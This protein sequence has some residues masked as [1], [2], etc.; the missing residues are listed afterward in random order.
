MCSPG[1]PVDFQHNV[2]L[3]ALSTGFVTGADDPVVLYVSDGNT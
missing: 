3:Y 2:P 1:C